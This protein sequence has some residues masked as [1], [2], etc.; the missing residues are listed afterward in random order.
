MT[1]YFRLFVAFARFGLATEMAF[2]ANFLVKILVEM[3]W[4]G[5]LLVFYQMVFGKTRLVEVVELPTDLHPWFVG[6]QAHPEFK[7]RPNRPSPLYRDFIGA[8]LAHL[9][10]ALREMQIVD[11]AHDHGGYAGAATSQI[12]QSIQAVQTAIQYRDAHTP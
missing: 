8:A 5:I 6:T 12:E 3:L 7:S 1:R 2:R 11:S 4:L 9:E 10:A